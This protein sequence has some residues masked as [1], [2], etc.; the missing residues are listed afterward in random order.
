MPEWT[1]RINEYALANRWKSGFSSLPW[2]IDRICRI[3]DR[4]CKLKLSSPINGMIFRGCE[5][6]SKS[7]SFVRTLRRL[8]AH[9]EQ[10]AR[11]WLQRMEHQKIS[12]II[13]PDNCNFS[14]I[15]PEFHSTQ[16]LYFGFQVS[17]LDCDWPA[18]VKKLNDFEASG[19]FSLL[20]TRRSIQWAS[21]TKW[22]LCGQRLYCL[23]RSMTERRTKTWIWIQH[24][25]TRKVCV[26]LPKILSQTVDHQIE[27]RLMPVHSNW[28]IWI[29][30][31]SSMSREFDS[32]KLCPSMQSFHFMS[33]MSNSA[34]LSRRCF[35]DIEKVIVCIGWPNIFW[36][37]MIRRNPEGN[38]AG[39]S[40]SDTD[41]FY[42]KRLIGRSNLRDYR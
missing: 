37:L 25:S 1:L 2:S 39:S 7:R 6:S 8:T 32:L 33:D 36:N 20:L 19:N 23:A 22:D 4:V 35:R 12:P 9:P 13:Y 3:I 5:F 21:L 17:L 28:E 16:C 11:V 34:Y 40:R 27:T 29:S 31:H 38:H 42:S 15:F 26:L 24:Q 18:A 30:R 10:S 41:Q 14:Q